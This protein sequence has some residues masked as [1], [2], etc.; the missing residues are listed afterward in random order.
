MEHE[1]YEMYGVEDEEEG[2]PSLGEALPTR[3]HKNIAP[4]SKAA[5]A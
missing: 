4:P 1:M 3:V 5:V 2:G